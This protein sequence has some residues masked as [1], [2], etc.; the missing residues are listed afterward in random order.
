[1]SQNEP[2]SNPDTEKQKA[3][4]RLA[5]AGAF[6]IIGQELKWAGTAL[7]VKAGMGHES[8][9]LLDAFRKL[10]STKETQEAA[11]GLVAAGESS[12]HFGATL[13]VIGR[14]LGNLTRA[15]KWHLIL[16]FTGAAVA[17]TVGWFRGGL[18]DDASDLVHHP[19]RSLKI[20]AGLESP[21]EKKSPE[22]NETPT[23]NAMSAQAE[24][25]VAS[26]TPTP[27]TT[28]QAGSIQRDATL[29]QNTTHHALGV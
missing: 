15:N 7:D 11:K 22:I 29:Q 3:G 26:T 27:A 8:G 20:V 13:K 19:I 24:T 5:V 4:S 9:N 25:A 23:I 14:N 16:G 12:S 2:L 18:L 6:A 17:G 28:I 1:M 21:P 10:F